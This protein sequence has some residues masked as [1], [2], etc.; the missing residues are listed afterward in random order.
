MLSYP[1]KLWSAFKNFAVSMS[2]V[3]ACDSSVPA[4]YLCIGM[5]IDMY[6]DM[7]MGMCEDKC[8]DM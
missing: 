4:V 3:L 8:E 5:R 7:H 6:I 1:E 2:A